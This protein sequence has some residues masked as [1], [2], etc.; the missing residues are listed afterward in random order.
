LTLSPSGF[1]ERPI[2]VKWVG[3]GVDAEIDDE[4]Q[5]QDMQQARA[6]LQRMQ[7]ATN[8]SG[9]NK[10]GCATNAE[11]GCNE[12][13]IRCNGCGLSVQRMRRL[14]G[15]TNANNGVQRMRDRGATDVRAGATNARA[16]C[17]E[18]KCVT[19][20]TTRATDA[21]SGVRKLCLGAWRASDSNTK[22]WRQGALPGLITCWETGQSSGKPAKRVY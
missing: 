7:G 21:Q 14:R 9:Y 3:G 1:G 12:C 15:A 22:W 11:W 17:N 20:T 2:L 16:G 5:V 10:C 18:C 8:A 13:E 19:N 4:W 6:G